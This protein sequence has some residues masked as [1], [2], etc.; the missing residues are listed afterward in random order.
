[1]FAL[2]LFVSFADHSASF[3]KQLKILWGALEVCLEVLAYR[4]KGEFAISSCGKR[5]LVSLS[6]AGV[7]VSGL[8]MSEMCGEQAQ[9]VTV[10]PFYE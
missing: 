6:R 3:G 2:V 1:V 7:A 8:G 10:D 5:Q 9:M 4:S